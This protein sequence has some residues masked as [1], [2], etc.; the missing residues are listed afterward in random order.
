MGINTHNFCKLGKYKYNIL[1][2]IQKCEIYAHWPRKDGKNKSGSG[3]TGSGSGSVKVFYTPP[4]S[5]VGVMFKNTWTK[6]LHGPILCLRLWKAL[7]KRNKRN[8]R[9]V[10]LSHFL[11][12]YWP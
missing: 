4:V 1:T 11:Q 5:T 3:K 6:I 9:G 12:I 7:L 2:D 8:F 10:G